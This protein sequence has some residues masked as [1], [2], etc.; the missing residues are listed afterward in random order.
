[1]AD[2][3]ARRAKILAAK[4]PQQPVANDRAGPPLA[5]NTPEGDPA[6]TDAPPEWMTDGLRAR[7]TSPVIAPAVPHAPEPQPKRFEEEDPFAAPR[8]A[9]RV[10]I[11]G[12]VA[13]AFAFGIIAGL[14]ML[15]IARMQEPGATVASLSPQ[16]VVEAPT[17]PAA[18]AVGESN[19]APQSDAGQ[20]GVSAITPTLGTPTAVE[21]AALGEI[22]DTAL[23]PADAGLSAVAPETEAQIPALTARWRPRSRNWP[24]PLPMACLSPCLPV[25]LPCLQMRCFRKRS[26]RR[27][28][29]SRC[30]RSM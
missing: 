13:G 26:P 22:G 15:M 27:P 6:L 29:P 5:D 23:P 19:A 8:R 14:G 18:I 10:A 11:I 3:R 7:D 25:V 28:C 1:M 24:R 9:R 21:T 16:P 17:L 4:G 2:A 30:R 12:Y 20:P